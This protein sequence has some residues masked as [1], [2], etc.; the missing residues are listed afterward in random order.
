MSHKRKYRKV[1]PTTNLV[2]SATIRFAPDLFT[3][4]VQAHEATVIRGPQSL[5]TALSLEAP[6]LPTLGVYANDPQ[7]GNALIQ[8]GASTR[9][10]QLLNPDYSFPEASDDKATW[11]DRYDARLLLD[12]VPE[13]A[14]PSA[15]QPR[16]LS[17]TGWSDL[18]SDTEDTFF[19]TPHEIEDYRREKRRRLIDQNREDRLRALAE[20][21]ESEQSDLWGGSD[22]EPD[23]VQS[24]LMKR[25]ALHLLSSPNPAQ[26]EMRI[27]ANHG[28]DK[29]FAFLRGR[30]SRAWRT[31]KE[32][33]RQ[34]KVDQPTQSLRAPRNVGL[35]GLAA[36]GESD[37]EDSE[38]ESESGET[39]L[40]KVGESS[41]TTLDSL[42]NRNVRLEEA[43]QEARRARAREW[44]TQRRA[45]QGQTLSTD[46]DRVNSSN[47]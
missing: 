45:R 37:D 4:S 8:W 46:E 27:L 44:A 36:Y 24:E 9:N 11:V 17:P 18:P 47:L 3:L 29:R 26:L 38:E 12:A 19:F 40:L 10:F 31:T 5:S 2:A 35:G 25:T 6:H 30:W 1:A 16:S 43:E 21:D 39:S 7:I 42:Q 15:S 28:A 20:T 34:E 32:R 14:S 22:E 33:L 41:A 13:H 23:D